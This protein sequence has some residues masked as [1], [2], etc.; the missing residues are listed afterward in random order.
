MSDRQVVKL[1]TG[2][3]V[4]FIAYDEMPGWDNKV[5][6][7]PYCAVDPTLEVG[8]GCYVHNNPGC[9]GGIYLA[10]EDF[11]AARLGTPPTKHRE[12]MR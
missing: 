2:T 11:V 10:E 3:K 5:S 1:N 8:N 9:A 4:F 7:C 12:S 6:P